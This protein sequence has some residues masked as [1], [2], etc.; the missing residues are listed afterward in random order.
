[1][2][3]ID[4]ETDTTPKKLRPYV[5]HGVDL[6]WGGGRGGNDHALADCPFCGKERK[7]SVNVE[8]GLWRC[9]VCGKGTDRGGGNEYTF[10]RELHGASV[11]ATRPE[12]YAGLARDRKLLYPETLVSWGVCRSAITGDWMVPGY[13]AE[14]KLTQLYKYVRGDGGR[15]V[16]KGTWEMNQ[17]LFGV[18]LWDGNK[19]ETHY[20]EGPWDGM[21]YWEVLRGTKLLEG[22][23]SPTSSEVASLLSDINV[24]AVPG[25]NS[26]PEAWTKLAGGKRVRLLYDNDHAREYPPG[27]GK[28]SRP[29]YDGMRRA[30]AI[31][32]RAE[33][34]PLEVQYLRWGGEGGEGFDPALPSGYDVRDSLTAA[35]EGIA[36]RAIALGGLLGKLEPVPADWVPGG[37]KANAHGTGGRVEVDCLPCKS[38]K[39]LLG[40]WRKAMKWTPGLEYALQVMLATASTVQVV[41]DQLWVIVMSPP[42]TGKSQLCEALSVNRDRVKAVS[43]FKGF[44]SA[45]QIDKEGSQNLSMVL[46]LKGKAFVVKDGDTILTLPNKD[47]IMGQARDLYDTKGS[48]VAGNMMSLD[49]QDLRFAWIL[50]GTKSLRMLDSSE[51][52]ERFLTCRIMDAIDSALEE[53]IGWRKI[54]QIRNNRFEVNGDLNSIETKEMLTA[55]RRTGGYLEYLRQNMGELYARV[56]MDDGAARRCMSLA[57]FV[58]YMRARPSKKQDEEESGREMNTRL[59]SQFGKLMFGLAVVMNKRSVD[60]EVVAVARH[61]CMDSSKGRVFRICRHLYKH[62]AVGLTLGGLATLCSSTDDKK[63]LLMNHLRTIGVVE[64]YVREGAGRGRYWRMTG[65]FRRL[66]EEVMQPTDRVR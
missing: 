55:R 47:Q 3:K 11:D 41:G 63:R 30:T 48:H 28:V 21:A 40:D 26:F 25:C 59:V 65:D 33:E 64:S 50:C 32:S 45:Y 24:L 31:F 56:E 22:K 54:N 66:Y 46:Q 14:G 57:K 18:D 61:V 4:E 39:D 36:Q 16:L 49:V 7:F 27:S 51:L 23:Y 20:C 35:G 1:M 17:G 53:D 60:E 8:T 5:F 19:A 15:M 38:W 58:A 42:S 43:T 62:G 34:T 12:D 29:G 9:Y 13:N 6:D 37:S 44:Y 2:P 52:G 10:L